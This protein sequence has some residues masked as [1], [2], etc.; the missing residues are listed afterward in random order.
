MS[1]QS[2]VS[3]P[4]VDIDSITP[5]EELLAEVRKTRITTP[6]TRVLLVL[7]VL[8]VGFLAGALVDR[9]Q[10]PASSSAAAAPL[11]P[12]VS[13]SADQPR[14]VLRASADAWVQV[15]DRSG[16]VLLNRILHAGDTWTV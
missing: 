9:W 1:D 6:F 5:D 3:P 12:P 15:R 16:P 8:S 10:R 4:L 11:P 14:I 2:T 7:I 13:A